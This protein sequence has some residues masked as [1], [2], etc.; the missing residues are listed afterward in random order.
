MKILSNTISNA[1]L[2]EYKR[3]NTVYNATVEKEYRKD[4]IQLL[5]MLVVKIILSK[6]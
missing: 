2:G 3:I 5:S 4:S 6:V 1:F